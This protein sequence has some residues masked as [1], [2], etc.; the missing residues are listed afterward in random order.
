MNSRDE[1]PP[2][3]LPVVHILAAV[4]EHRPSSSA[5][6]SPGDDRGVGGDVRLARVA[7][8]ELL[9][10]KVLLVL[11]AHAQGA[12]RRPG[13]FCSCQKVEKDDRKEGKRQKEGLSIPHKML[14]NYKR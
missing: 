1:H 12:R 4:D 9:F 6:E 8:E 5:V 13:C 14:H 3:V 10:V 7:H 2:L 11:P